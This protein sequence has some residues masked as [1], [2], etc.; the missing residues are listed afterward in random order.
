MTIPYTFVNGTL[1]NAD[2]VNSNFS[3]VERRNKMY[4]IIPSITGSWCTSPGSLSNT[5][6]ENPLTFNTPGIVSGTVGVNIDGNLIWDLGAI[7]NV[8]TVKAYYNFSGNQP[9]V[10]SYIEF[11]VGSTTSS[12]YMLDRITSISTGSS[13]NAV[14][15]IP[16]LYSNIRYIR[17]NVRRGAADTGSTI[18]SI[19]EIGVYA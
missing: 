6:D 14:Y 11:D 2:E 5:S 7:Y 9:S 1:A 16:P 3:Y 4:G 17:M 13:S 10:D 12:W 8:N 19:G 15:N 18:I